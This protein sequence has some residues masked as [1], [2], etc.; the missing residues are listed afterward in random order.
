M[1]SIIEFLSNFVQRPDKVIMQMIDAY[2]YWIYAILFI[3]IF[4]ETGL[5]IMTFLMPFLPGDALIFSIGMIAANDSQN[6]LHIEFIIP[7]LMVAAVLGDNVNYYVGRRFGHWI[8]QKEDSFFLKKKH[9]EK[10]TH[11]FNENGKKAIIIARFMPVVRTIIPFICGT[12]NLK[13]SVFLTYSILGALLWVGAIS[14][15]GYTLG[16]FEIVQQ[17][18]EKFIFGIII[19]AN[20]PLIIRLIKARFGQK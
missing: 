5:I 19:A 16:G 14:V 6:H 4:A 15:L 1:Q 2:G 10:A 20:M 12:T 18:L 11:F 3:I 7:L 8:L 17:H 9:L 13:Y